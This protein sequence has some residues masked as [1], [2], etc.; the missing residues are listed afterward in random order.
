MTQTDSDKLLYLLLGFLAVLG[1][2][3]TGLLCTISFELH[4]TLRSIGT[5][6]SR[7]ESTL[8]EAHQAV[9]TVR[10]VI[11][12]T[13][14]AAEIARSKVQAFLSRYLGYGNRPEL[15]RVHHR[16]RRH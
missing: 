16:K 12:Q 2:V 3:G 9:G 8:E 1:T 10:Q 13:Y 15:R 6:V 5:F 11:D 4:R 7:A 14:D